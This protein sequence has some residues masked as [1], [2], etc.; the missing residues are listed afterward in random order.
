MGRRKVRKKNRVERKEGVRE[1]GKGEKRESLTSV[2]IIITTVP[3]SA[4][5]RLNY[6]CSSLIKI[7]TRYCAR[8]QPLYLSLS[9][10]SNQ[11]KLAV[12]P[13]C[14]FQRSLSFHL[15]FLSY[16]RTETHTAADTHKLSHRC[17][18]RQYEH[19]DLSI[20]LPFYSYLF[21]L[22]LSLSSSQF[23]HEKVS[24]GLVPETE[25]KD[26]IFYRGE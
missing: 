12:F 7:Q 17:L 14:L 8:F 5:V 6:G 16:V 21:P 2:L 18:A 24:L 11:T 13:C 15:F 26:K 20:S 1:R 23:I 19:I 22:F 10:F 9:L 25:R 4:K 3:Q